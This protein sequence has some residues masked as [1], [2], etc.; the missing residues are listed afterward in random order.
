MAL[1]SWFKHKPLYLQGGIIGI[2]VCILLAV[3]YM[4]I[5]NAFLIQF[6]PDG[7]LPGYSLLLPVATGHFFVF[8]AHFV[9]EGYIVP[10]VGCVSDDCFARAD[11]ITFAITAII[12]LLLY[13][14]I[15]A[16][17]GWFVQKM[18]KKTISSSPLLP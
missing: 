5:Y 1:Q 13:F 15:G 14:G 17:V 18:K 12:L 9:A 6:F 10:V 16:T 11:W 3:F 4:T 7:Q 8:A 2:L